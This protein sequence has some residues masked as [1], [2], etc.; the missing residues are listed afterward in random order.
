MTRLD[1]SCVMSDESVRSMN[2]YKG[3]T[4]GSSLLDYSNTLQGDSKSDQEDIS[5]A[6]KRLESL[7]VSNT[8]KTGKDDNEFKLHTVSLDDRDDNTNTTLKSFMFG[9]SLPDLKVE[10]EFL[11]QQ[12]AER[13]NQIND[14][15][16][17]VQEGKRNTDRLQSR[18]NIFLGGPNT[19]DDVS[20]HGKLTKVYK[21]LQDVEQERDDYRNKSVELSVSLADAK[22]KVSTLESTLEEYQS[23]VSSSAEGRAWWKKFRNLQSGEQEEEVVAV[24]PAKNTPPQV[25]FLKMSE[26]PMDNTT[27]N[28]KQQEDR[29]ASDSKPW[30]SRS[31]KS[32]F[33]TPERDNHRSEG[34]E[35]PGTLKRRL[36]SRL[37]G[38][39]SRGNNTTPVKEANIGRV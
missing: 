15:Q 17:K 9:N 21:Q 39:M 20:A 27:G 13:D 24:E 5:F 1:T 36:G 4:S 35:S 19:K 28:D 7:S 34:S 33:S 14:L 31:I 8:T 11:R 30:S 6:S 18:L 10:V 22:A 38:I 3:N 16:Q 12:L 23:L 25:T 26:M 32:Y 2:S 29:D 37:T